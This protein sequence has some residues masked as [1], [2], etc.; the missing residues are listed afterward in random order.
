MSALLEFRAHSA[1]MVAGGVTLEDPAEESVTALITDIAIACLGHVFVH[2]GCMV[3][4]AIYRVPGGHMAQAVPRNVT[5]FKN[6]PLAVTP[7]REAVSVSLPTTEHNVKKSVN[8]ASMGQAVRRNV[9]VQVED[10]VTPR[11]DNADS[12]V[13]QDFMETNVRKPVK[14]ENMERTAI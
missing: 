11:L 12:D 10:H 9:T 6:I 2:Q 1:R 3:A 13:L 4:S 8:W 5:V 7:K 14:L